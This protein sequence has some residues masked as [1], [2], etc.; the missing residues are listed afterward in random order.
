MHQADFLRVAHAGTAGL[1]VLDD[2][3]RLRLVG[4][5]VYIDV[6]DA[7]ARLDTGD[8]GV[9]GAG[10]DQS[11]APTGDEQIHIA[12]GGHQL[13]GAG[14]GG[15]LDEIHAGLRQA[16]RFQ[17]GTEGGDDG[18]GTA[19]GVAAGA[20][21]AHVAAL[22]TQGGGVTGHVGTALVND[23]HHAHGHGGLLDDHAGLGGGTAA[24]LS[25][26]VRQVDEG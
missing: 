26:R 16:S 1:G 5:G 19:P 20:Q 6:A 17:T 18:V 14:V 9:L 10:A 21:D 11:S 25:H 15:V 2:V 13:V 4:G 22:E 24:H 3:Q 12:H 7:R 8:G 23:S